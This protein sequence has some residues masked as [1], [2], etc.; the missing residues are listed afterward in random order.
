MDWALPQKSALTL[1]VSQVNSWLNSPNFFC[2]KN[3]NFYIWEI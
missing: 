1:T 2:T 3:Q